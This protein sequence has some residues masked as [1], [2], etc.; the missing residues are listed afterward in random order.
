LTL[1][2]LPAFIA[3]YELVKCGKKLQGGVFLGKRKCKKVLALALLA[4]FL[5]LN[6]QLKS[7]RP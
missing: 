7:E 1:P 5:F 6:N 2:P 3:E 4:L